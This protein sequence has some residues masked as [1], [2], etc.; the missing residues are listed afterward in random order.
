MA[1]QRHIINKQIL[2]IQL[3]YTANVFEEQQQL[4]KLNN[5]IWVPIIQSVLGNVDGGS[6]TK[7]LQ[8]ERLILDL[9]V[10]AMEEIT[11]VFKEKLEEALS[12]ILA[13]RERQ[14]TVAEDSSIALEETPLLLLAYFLK[15][16][17][18]PWWAKAGT[19]AFL[20]STLETLLEEPAIAFI[21]LLQE[22][23]FNI[24]YLERYLQVC[25]T[26]QII[27]SL[28]LLTN[29]SVQELVWVKKQLLADCEQHFKINQEIAVASSIELTFWKVAFSQITISKSEEDLQKACVAQT[30]LAVGINPVEPNSESQHLNT[31]RI[32][33]L[34]AKLSMQHPHNA[35][36]SEFFRH[37]L[38]VVNAPF[39]YKVNPKLLTNFKRE[40]EILDL[41]LKENTL[42]QHTHKGISHKTNTIKTEAWLKPLVL[43]FHA[44]EA[45][46]AIYHT[47]TKPLMIDQLQTVFN[48][49]DFIT[50]HNAG[51]VLFWPFLKRFFENLQLLEDMGFSDKIVQDKAI[52][53]LQYLCDEDEERL[54]EGL[55]PLNKVLCGV[56]LDDAVVPVLLSKAEKE[57]VEG[58]LQSVLKKGPHW[59]NLS[60]AGFRSS[61]L[62][63]EGSLRTRNGHWLLQVK[64][65]TYDI[66]L[67]K[68][69]W[70]FTTVKLPWMNEIL[71]VEWI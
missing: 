55:L 64:K 57:S 10:V 59:A 47:G 18:L 69:P 5:E 23:E 29:S 52:C 56:S 1:E 2:E 19:K 61:Y 12:E 30:L 16:G 6:E 43:H 34:V 40:L 70:G 33:S 42:K 3:P 66:T 68:L 60:I 24:L 31:G 9:G 65:E 38:K 15:N 26:K 63:R 32:Q 21:Q 11:A 14:F 49:T 44:L 51:L 58:L 25:S 41:A 17:L 7:P 50:I 54:F 27:K 20:Q 28:E 36:W 71:I 67:E 8:I 13:V 46:L 48:D 53:A 22:L 62:C 37:V 35:V 4:S 45:N 39:F